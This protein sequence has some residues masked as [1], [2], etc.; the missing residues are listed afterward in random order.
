M[1]NAELSFLGDFTAALTLI[2]ISL[3]NVVSDFLRY[4]DSWGFVHVLVSRKG[5][6]EQRRKGKSYDVVSL[7]IRR[8]SS[9]GDSGSLI[10][11]I[12]GSSGQNSRVTLIFIFPFCHS[13]ELNL[14]I[15]H[16][17]PS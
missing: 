7:I 6:K 2:F 10:S 4:G 13:P 15:S 14:R 5:A 8:K 12:S 3:E 11:A 9:R 17:I 1:I 16:S